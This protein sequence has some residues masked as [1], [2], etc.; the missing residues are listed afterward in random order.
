MEIIYGPLAI[1]NVH[2]DVYVP[3]YAYPGTVTAKLSVTFAGPSPEL[4]FAL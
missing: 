4:V 2:V 1:V 3:E